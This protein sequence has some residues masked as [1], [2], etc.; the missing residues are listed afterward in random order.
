MTAVLAIAIAIGVAVGFAT[1][2][3]LARLRGVHIRSTALLLGGAA[4]QVIV[5]SGA[6]QVGSGL[7]LAAV[8][9]SYLALA[10]FAVRNLEHAGM[11]L[12]LVGVAL[13]ALPIAVD[14]GMPV[15]GH[16]IVSAGLAKAYEVPLLDFGGKRHLATGSDH[17][18]ALDDRIPDWMTHQ[19]L[20][21]GDLVI[22]VG[23]GTVVAGLLRPPRRRRGRRR[24][25]RRRRSS[26]AVA[27]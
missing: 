2:G 11:G 7:T 1:G 9:I 26:G 23:V 18:R 13:N 3:R 10:V 20:S 21:V 25:G 8:L 16:A 4:L 19:V 5:L 14:R 17:L 12:V 6:V 22:T 15:E 27:A 24:R